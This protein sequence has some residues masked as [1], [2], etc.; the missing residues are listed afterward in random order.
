[1]LFAR[2][3][4]RLGQDDNTICILFSFYLWPRRRMREVKAR[5]SQAVKLG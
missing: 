5:P 3:K 2:D 4:K 1:M